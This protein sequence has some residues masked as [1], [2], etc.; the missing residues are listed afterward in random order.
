[1]KA[2]VIFDL[3]GTLIESEQ[4]WRDVR[5]EFVT[6]NGG[7]WRPDAAAAMI[8][9][10]TSEWARY[11]HDELGVALAPEQIAERVVTAVVQRLQSR[12]CCPAPMP[13]CTGSRV[14]FG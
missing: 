8:G 9:M 6:T 14:I 3:D 5:R 12:R 13:R 7:R 4:I 1:M 10:R 2:D 11:M